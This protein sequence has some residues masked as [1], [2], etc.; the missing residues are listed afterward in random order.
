MLPVLVAAFDGFIPQ[1]WGLEP[2]R[3]PAPFVALEHQ[4][5]APAAI[6]AG[7]S[8]FPE[9]SKVAVVD[10]AFLGQ[11]FNRDYLYEGALHRWL[12]DAP[13]DPLVFRR[14]ET[15]EVADILC[16]TRA[17]AAQ[18]HPLAVSTHS[19]EIE[20]ELLRA[21]PR[22]KTFVF[23]DSHVWN[24][25]AATDRIGLRGVVVETVHVHGGEQLKVCRHQGPVTMHRW[26]TGDEL[27]PDY[28]RQYG[29][30]DGDWVVAVCGEIDIRN[31][32][33]R[34]AHERGVPASRVI[35]ELCSRFGARLASALRDLDVNVALSCPIPP[36]DF[37]ELGRPDV[38]AH[39]GTI[40]ERIATT[41]AFRA[42]LMAEARGRE[43]SVLDVYDAFADSRGALEVTRSDYFCHVG[44]DHKRPAV[45]VLARLMALPHRQPPITL[46]ATRPSQASG[47][48][49]A[50]RRL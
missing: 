17:S 44:H 30:R 32:I 15:G 6:A 23:G 10:G 8:A 22:R 9:A 49:V 29:V 35:Q 47:E 18:A 16:V 12:A 21:D 43:W 19:G 39:V 24:L 5:P 42:R 41:L 33:G 46:S 25:Y 26:A 4:L 14:Q 45:D 50:E 11:F 38:V 34:I 20:L 36:L 7:F 1:D 31:H 28:F 2:T 48:D 37:A 13:E 27:T 3:I 40:E